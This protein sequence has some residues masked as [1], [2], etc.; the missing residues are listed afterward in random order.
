MQPASGRWT[1]LQLRASPRSRRDQD[2]RAQ[3]EK[4]RRDREANAG[5]AA[6]DER[7]LAAKRPGAKARWASRPFCCDLRGDAASVNEIDRHEAGRGRRPPRAPLAATAF[8]VPRTTPAAGSP[9]STGSPGL[10]P[11]RQPYCVPGVQP[12][13]AE[14]H[15]GR[16][17]SSTRRTRACS[18]CRR[19]YSPHRVARSLG[20][21]LPRG[22]QTRVDA[23]GAEAA[24]DA[25]G[26][27]DGLRPSFAS[28]ADG[29][30]KR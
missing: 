5:P 13:A 17:A 11:L 27:R 24:G 8:T 29:Y 7:P 3:P 14:A 1:V 15:F 22:A 23:G 6:R 28:S 16:R 12:S 25:V 19:K 18:C 21:Q 4:L 9:A 20:R 10:G 30:A 26:G 2:G